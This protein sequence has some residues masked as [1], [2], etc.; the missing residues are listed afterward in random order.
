[1]LGFIFAV[2]AGALTPHAIGPLARPV[3]KAIADQIEVEENELPLL[4]FALLMVLAGIACAIF[5]T[6]SPAGLA[7]G[8]LVGYFATRLV[9]LV[10]RLLDGNP[11]S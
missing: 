3:A 5:D 11:N 9:A 4:S 8:G 2:I 7:V 1:M 10:K 6:G